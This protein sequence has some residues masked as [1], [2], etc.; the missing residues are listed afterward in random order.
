MSALSVLITEVIQS[1]TEL[2]FGKPKQYVDLIAAGESGNAKQRLEYD[3]I[4]IG[5]GMLLF[6]IYLKYDQ[7]SAFF[8]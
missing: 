5:G 2:I 6:F 7:V 8:G 4:I 3:I 1:L